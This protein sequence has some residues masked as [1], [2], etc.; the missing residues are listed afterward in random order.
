MELPIKITEN[1][2][3][4]ALYIYQHKNIPPSY[5]LRIGTKGGGGCGGASYFIGFDTQKPEDKSF[6]FQG[7]TVLI[8]K[9]H[10]LYLAGMQLDFEERPEERGFVFKKEE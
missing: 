6:D 5:G 8:D 1:A 9:R 2:L 3:K 10:F 4:E 7:I